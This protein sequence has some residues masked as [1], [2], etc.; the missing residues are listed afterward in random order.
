MVLRF[1]IRFPPTRPI[2]RS[3]CALCEL[4]LPGGR[5]KRYLKLP[6]ST[7]I[8]VLVQQTRYVLSQQRPKEYVFSTFEARNGNPREVAQLHEVAKLEEAA[9]GWN[10][11]LSPDGKTIAAATFGTDGR[12]KLLS[13]AGEPT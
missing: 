6:T 4:Q 13:L 5:L 8:S 10:W 3:R 9:L 7:T 11:S 12:I 2:S 1:F